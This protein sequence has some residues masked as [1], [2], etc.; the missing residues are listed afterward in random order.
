MRKSYFF[1]IILFFSSHFAISQSADVTKGC[2]PLSVQFSADS[3]YQYYWEFEEGN[4]TSNLQNPQ[5]IF[6]H[7]GK[8][9]VKLYNGK[10]K[11]K[12]GEIEITV[13]ADPI[14]TFEADTTKGCVPLEVNFTP[15]IELDSELTVIKYKW[16]FGDGEQSDVKN[17]THIYTVSGVFKVSLE[18]VTNL[19]ECNKIY[20]REQYINTNQ[21]SVDFIAYPD[22]I[23]DSKG[24]I[25]FTNLTPNHFDYSY[26]WD[27]DN[28]KTST[29]FSDST[30]YDKPGVYNVELTVT[31]PE[32][33]TVTR[34][35]KITIGKPVFNLEFPDTA[36]IY[37][38]YNNRYNKHTTILNSTIAKKF[39]WTFYDSTEYIRFQS[40]VINGD[41]VEDVNAFLDYQQP[42]YK[43]I[44][45]RAYNSDDCFSDTTFTIFIE[46]PDPS[47]TIDPEISCLDPVELKLK[48][49]DS[50]FQNYHWYVEGSI[51]IFKN[52]HQAIYV[53]DDPPH[54]SLHINNADPVFINLLITTKHGCKD[55]FY[56]NY[57]E[58][59][60]NA[61]FRLDTA[62]GCAPLTVTFFDK[63]N[64]N[65][66]IIEWKYYHGTGD[67][68]IT[69]HSINHKFTYTEPGEYY[70]K[71][72]IQNELGCIDTSDGQYIKVGEPIPPDFELDKTEICLGDSITGIFKNDDERID[73]Y[74]IDFDDGRSNHCWRDNTFSYVPVTKAGVYPV[75]ASIEYNGCIATDSTSY[76]VTVNGAKAGIGYFIDCKNP[77]DVLLR[78]KS[79]GAN[80]YMWRINNDSIFNR[81]SFYYHFDTTGEYT[82]YLEAID[83]TVDCPV[84]I[85]ST[86]INITHIKADFDIPDKI[87]D[88]KW[89]S[90]NAKNSVDV[91][92]GCKQPYLWITSFYRPFKTHV[93]R[94]ETNIPRGHQTITLVVEDI[95]GC[96]DTL[97]KE[98]TSYNVNASF[99]LDH[100]SFCIPATIKVHNTT[101]SDTTIVKWE[102]KNGPKIK[103]PVFTIP[104]SY[105]YNFYNFELWVTDAIG[106]KDTA[107]IQ[108]SK[109]KPESQIFLY[110]GDHICKGDGIRFTANDFTQQGS[111]LIFKWNLENIDTFAG[112]TNIVTI[113][114]EGDYKLF[115]HFEEEKS[116]CTGD[117]DTTI[118]VVDFPIADFVTDV[119]SLNTICYPRIVTFKNN[120]IFDGLG[121]VRWYFDNVTLSNP[122]K[123]LQIVELPKGKHNVQL[124]AN[125]YYGCRDT[126]VKSFVL[127]GPEGKVVTDKNQICLGEEIEFRLTDTVDVNQFEWDFGDGNTAKD[128]NPV[129]HK[130]LYN[131]DSTNAKVILKSTANGCEISLDIPITVYEV[132]ADFEKLDTAVYCTGHAYLKNLSVG[133]DKFIWSSPDGEVK[134]DT[135]PVFMQFPNA[136]NY[137]V[138]LIAINSVTDCRDTINKVIELEEFNRLYV[139]PNIFTPNGDNENDYFRPVIKNEDFRGF[140][141][142]NVFK[143]YNRWGNL[144]YDNS[145][146]DK[147]WDGN[148][149]NKPAPAGVYGYYLEADISGCEII[150]EKG[151]ITLLR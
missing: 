149:N 104:D 105:L 151:N 67:S 12:I 51:E 44:S 103:E 7:P 79:I 28:G 2:S 19:T 5:H 1:Y 50:T 39:E 77:D 73:G 115:L 127:V 145:D 99:E 59:K 40:K 32:G 49:N 98:L 75:K 80:K 61:H 56:K 120:S 128:I 64:S 123:P 18:I 58:K 54:D 143:V 72:I 27:F 114:N 17:P 147:G 42:G 140:I 47:F 30:F 137:N 142:F 113:P 78:N 63:S 109:Y 13:F 45:L 118:Y 66:D 93:P 31:S 36:C 131:L 117:L 60:P 148:F 10:G 146:P 106:C 68:L 95:N 87:C 41:T 96:K 48:A 89:L 108:L 139:V 29:K 16:A 110:P 52:K 102:W 65:E 14:I 62:Q 121:Y 119:D 8:Y 35:K 135:N 24:T 23:C 9:T 125:S 33:C 126:I 85:D 71:L 84:N 97:T 11:S 55:I 92:P 46:D 81:D 22:N 134:N 82:L 53:Y 144:V 37:E 26:F 101:T 136:G 107:F 150:K 38:Y 122:T 90:I 88:Y 70:A 4:A 3:L 21:L 124:V 34:Q 141:K 138:T 83:T 25:Q 133:A 20:S 132:I 130:F 43:T 74:H 57:F 100:N 6:T 91:G 111:N 86:D 69:D 15:N 76:T 94:L 129:K 112:Q 116:G